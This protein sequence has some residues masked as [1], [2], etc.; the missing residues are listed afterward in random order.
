MQET[1]MGSLIW[2][3]P[4]CRGAARPLCTTAIEPVLWSP[5]AASTEAQ[6]PTLH[7]RGAPAMRSPSSNKDPAKVNK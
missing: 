5:G 7:K 2:E 3:D 6:D 1:Q 4:A